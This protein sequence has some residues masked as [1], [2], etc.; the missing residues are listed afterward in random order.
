MPHK[1]TYLKKNQLFV[2][3]YIHIRARRQHHDTD[4]SWFRFF[5]LAKYV[6]LVFQF[7]CNQ[8]IQRP[9]ASRGIFFP[10]LV[11]FILLTFF[12]SIISNI[13]SNFYVNPF[14]A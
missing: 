10:L 12:A 9:I 13:E 14:V 11:A 7:A 2:F 5:Y 6:F 4:I 1:D 8:R 3:T